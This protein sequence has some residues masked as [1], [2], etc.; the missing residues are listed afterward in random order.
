MSSRLLT[1]N[2][3]EILDSVSDLIQNFILAHTIWFMISTETNNNQAFLLVHDCL[4]DMPAG[5]QVREDHGAHG[6]IWLTLT[7]LFE[8]DSSPLEMKIFIWIEA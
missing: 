8:E 4:V 7:S 5:V 6:E 2:R 1:I 3:G